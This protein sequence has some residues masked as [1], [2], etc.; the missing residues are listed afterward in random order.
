MKL[1]PC[2]NQ[3]RNVTP[4]ASVTKKQSNEHSTSHNSSEKVMRDSSVDKTKDSD[5]ILSMYTVNTKQKK[6]YTCTTCN[7]RFTV[8]S[9]VLRHLLVHLDE[10]TPKTKPIE[11][12]SQNRV[13]GMDDEV[14]FSSESSEDENSTPLKARVTK[15]RNKRVVANDPSGPFSVTTVTL[16][17]YTRNSMFQF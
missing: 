13:T 6:P 7:Q 4:K 17:R 3:A 1:N 15:K 2:F 14:L 8:K 11:K 10:K 16:P 12:D 9:G 5:P